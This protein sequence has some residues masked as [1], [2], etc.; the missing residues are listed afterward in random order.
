MTK[1]IDVAKYILCIANTNGDLITNLKLQKLLYYAQAWYMVNFD[2]KKLF[3]DDIEAW[4]F[5]PVIKS[6]YNLFKDF[7]RKPIILSDAECSDYDLTETQKSYL[8][9]FCETFLRY[10]IPP[11]QSHATINTSDSNMF[12]T[13]SSLSPS[14]YL[15]LPILKSSLALV[16]SL[17]DHQ[18]CLLQYQKVTFATNQNK[19]YVNLSS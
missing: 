19:H 13:S 15:T 11:D 5:G 8:A 16:I 6:I 4:Q 3:D 10:S 2:G 1:A 7:G 17:I 9:E 14:T 18:N 12:V